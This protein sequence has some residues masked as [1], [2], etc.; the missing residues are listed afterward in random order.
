MAVNKV[1]RCLP[2]CLHH[3]LFGFE[4][5]TGEMVVVSTRME[6]RPWFVADISIEFT[7]KIRS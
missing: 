1:L 2:F 4:I 6:N 3:L 7:G 5:M